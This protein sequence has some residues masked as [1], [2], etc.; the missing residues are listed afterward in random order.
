MIK[1]YNSV[2]FFD[3]LYSSVI[4]CKILVSKKQYHEAREIKQNQE[5]KMKETRLP[6][7]LYSTREINGIQQQGPGVHLR[8]LE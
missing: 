5:A 3:K 2:F 7:F 8:E 4:F 1:L 6:T